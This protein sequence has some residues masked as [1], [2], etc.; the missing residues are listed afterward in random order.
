MTELFTRLTHNENDWIVPSGHSWKKEN[1]GKKNIPYEN[2]YGFGH[3]EWLFNARYRV[4]GY[5]YG[6]IRGLKKFHNENNIAE[7]VHLYTVKREGSVRLVYYLGF[8]NDVQLLDEDWEIKFPKV[9]KI[10]KEYAEAVKSEVK[11][12]KGD[13]TG[14]SKDGFIP[15][16]R[17]K[18]ANATLLGKPMLLKRF[19]LNKYKRFQP[20][21]ITKEIHE[22]FTAVIIE[23]EITPFFFNPG[24]ASQTERFN[25]YSSAS[26]KSVIKIHSKIIDRLELVEFLF[27]KIYRFQKA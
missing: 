21:R 17:F 12:S 18:T 10:Y 13:K 23:K 8:I 26:E 2:Q 20:Y 5:Q 27:L 14:L 11:K 15:V 1:Q 3:E 7:R 22:V 24:K 4:E 9:S 25:R 19:P 16:V 6:Y